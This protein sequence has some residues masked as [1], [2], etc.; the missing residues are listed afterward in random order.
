MPIK[1]IQ[2]PIKS[3]LTRATRATI[4]VFQNPG[5]RRSI[6]TIA[7]KFIIGTAG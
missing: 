5:I 7:R 3:Q 6:E 2:F 4:R 1:E